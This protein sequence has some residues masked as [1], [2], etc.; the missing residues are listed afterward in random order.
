MSHKT[1]LG[2]KGYSIYKDSLTLK[3]QVFIREELTVKP[4][5]PKSPVQLTPYPIYR[6]SNKK[7]YIPRKFGFDTFG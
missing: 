1:Y 4:Y 3:E 2:N 5:T 6:E 7:F